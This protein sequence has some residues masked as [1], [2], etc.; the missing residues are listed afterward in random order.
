M[1]SNPVLEMSRKPGRPAVDR[2]DE[3]LDAAQRIYDRIGFEKTTI[4]DIAGDL[5]MSP[6]NIYRSFSNRRA[7]DEAVAARKLSQIEDAAW[8]GARSTSDAPIALRKMVGNVHAVSRKLMFEQGRLNELCA[9]AAREHWA[10]V[11]TYLNGLRGAIRHVIMEGQRTGVF[12]KTDPEAAASTVLHSLMAVWHPRM[13]EAAGSRD[14][15]PLADD[16]CELIV[17]GLSNKLTI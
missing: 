15:T 10:V 7:I 1:K 16:L 4:G 8:R 3:I 12:A 2:R 9:T 17:N 11:D 13:I 6:A 5:S 14:L